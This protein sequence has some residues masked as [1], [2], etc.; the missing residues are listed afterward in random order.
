MWN[1]QVV[2]KGRCRIRLQTTYVFREITEHA[3]LNEKLHRNFLN[4]DVKIIVDIYFLICRRKIL[5]K[6]LDFFVG[7]WSLSI[8]FC[9]GSLSMLQCTC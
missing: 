3:L 4:I 7:F 8:K 1:L 5:V 9:L 2:C 6:I